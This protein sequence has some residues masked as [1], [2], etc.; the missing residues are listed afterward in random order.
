MTPGVYIEEFEIGA[1]P[2]EGVSTSTAGFLGQTERGPISPRLITGIDEYTRIFG[3]FIENSYLTYAVHGFFA[4][5]GKRCY[6]GRITRFG[7][8]ASDEAAT[9]QSTIALPGTSNNSIVIM[10]MGP[11]DYGQRIF[12]KIEPPTQPEKPPAKPK[13]TRFR[14][15]LMYFNSAPPTPIVDPTSIDPADRRNPNRREPAWLEVYDNISVDPRSSS[16]YRNEVLGSQL[17]VFYDNIPTTT[18]AEPP[19]PPAPVVLTPLQGGTNGTGNIDLDDYKG[20]ED[21]IMDPI[22]GTLMGIRRTGLQGLKAIDDI[23]IVCAPD[24]HE[25]TGLRAE[26]IDHC[27]D[28]KYRFAVL[29][30]KRSDVTD[31]GALEPDLESKY[32]ALYF[33]WIKVIDPLTRDLKLIPP[34][35]HI[36]GIYARNDIEKGVHKSPANERVRG[37]AALQTLI[38]KEQQGPL[39]LK[40]VNCIRAFPGRGILVWGARTISRDMLWKYINVRRLFIYIERSIDEGSQW[41]VFEVNSE[42]LWSRVV[43]TITQFLTRVWKDGMLMGKTPEEGF[44]VK[45]DRTTMTQDDIDNGRLIVIIGLAVVKP[46]EYVIFRLAQT[47]SGAE[48][49]ELGGT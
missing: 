2:I 1:K 34:G 18:N 43:A 10:A 4:N 49:E 27:E 30:S 38:T 47:K 19:N 44:F 33:P 5:G 12:Y 29:Q 20:K 37:V 9:S 8:Q 15:T 24:E 16:F 11:G 23:S 36:A 31:I 28:L 26:L 32:A 25:V 6:V 3:G 35:G 21:Q 14:L 45:C 40:G 41:L 48:I 22:T 39:N 42:R 17:A 7:T 13:N 46:A